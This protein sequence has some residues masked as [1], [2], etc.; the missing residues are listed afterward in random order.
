V[1]DRAPIRALAARGVPIRAIARDL[2]IS[3]NTVRRA[4]DPERPD[5]Y[6]RASHLDALG[7]DVRTVLAAY[8]HMSA[9]GV[10]RRLH[11]RGAHSHFTP[12]VNQIR[13]EVLDADASRV[14]HRGAGDDL[15]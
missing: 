7:A 6:V 2:G 3:R 10:A 4:L 1:H 9:A 15:G 11:Y 13:R 5:H 8:P 12:F 14:V